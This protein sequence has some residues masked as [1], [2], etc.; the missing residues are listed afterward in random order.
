MPKKIAPFRWKPTVNDGIYTASDVAA[1]FKLNYKQVH[2]WFGSYV[3]NRL[4]EKGVRYFYERHGVTAVNFLTLIEMYV[5][6]R[7]REN[8]IQP[9]Q[10]L[11]YHSF[12]R[13][14]HNTEYPF[15]TSKILLSGKSLYMH[16]NGQ[17]MDANETF[18]HVMKD[19][20]LPWAEQIEFDDGIAA[21][22][23]PLR[24][25]KTV[26]VS[27]SHQFGEPTVSGT[28]IKT[29]TVHRLYSSGESTE[30]IARLYELERQQVEDAIEF[31]NAA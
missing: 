1:I 30:F 5:F 15:A 3:K 27:K 29:S 22:F 6:Y 8:K 23:Y 20:I 18:Q 9:R 10:I 4:P 19:V 11:E 31:A 14:L 17:L 21:R 7:M 13:K 16:H 2:Y 28:N 12:L 26:V 24:N 25:K